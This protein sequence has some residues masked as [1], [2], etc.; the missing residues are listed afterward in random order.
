[1]RRGWSAKRTKGT[2][3][4]SRLSPCL[5]KTP[6]PHFEGDGSESRH[7]RPVLWEP[8]VI[9]GC[10]LANGRLVRWQAPCAPCMCVRAWGANLNVNLK[11]PVDDG[12]NLPARPHSAL[13]EGSVHTHTGSPGCAGRLRRRDNAESGSAVLRT[14]I[15]LPIVTMTLRSSC[16]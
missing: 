16:Q 1:M 8:S 4:G 6:G 5:L 11:L 12:A 2:P 14:R 7:L 15:V 10:A 13:T 9:Q 3:P